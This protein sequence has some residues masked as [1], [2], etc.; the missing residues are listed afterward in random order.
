MD[1]GRQPIG[2]Q[3]AAHTLVVFDPQAQRPDGGTLRFH[4]AAISEATDAI[5]AFG[6][7]QR[8]TPTCVSTSSWHSEQ[9]S[10]VS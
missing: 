7:Q 4:R 10:A 1:I 5:T 6:A 2:E 9:L 3:Q 8:I